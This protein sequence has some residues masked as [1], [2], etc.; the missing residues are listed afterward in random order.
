MQKKLNQSEERFTQVQVDKI[1]WKRGERKSLNR[2]SYERTLV[3]LK[4]EAAMRGLMGEIITRIERKGFIITAM[5]LIQLDRKQAERIYEIHK[6]KDFYEPLIKHVTSGPILV[7]IIEGPNAISSI[8]TMAGK[9]N[10]AEAQSGTIRGDYALITRKNMIHAADT[11]ENARREIEIFFKSNEI[12]K[13]KK[14]TESQ[15][16]L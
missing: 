12:M 16:L 4:P 5:K 11:L 14:P 8:R 3:F 6:G 7:M 9:T 15:Y 10:P 1:L 13:Y 2:P